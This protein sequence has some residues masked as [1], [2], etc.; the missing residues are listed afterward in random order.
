M[1]KIIFQNYAGQ[2]Y[3]KEYP[4]NEL[5]FI[6]NKIE[7]RELV[8]REN[9]KKAGKNPEEGYSLLDIGCG[10]GFLL[11]HFHDKGAHV[12]G[13]DSGCTRWSIFHPELLSCFGAGR[14][15]ETASADGGAERI[16]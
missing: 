2:T 16:L 4:E 8:I 13:I 5:A 1:R 9:L 7:E 12:K 14:Y 15:G 6:Q 10:E 3:A 11:K